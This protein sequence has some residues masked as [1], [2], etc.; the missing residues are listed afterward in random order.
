[1]IR[2]STS[3]HGDEIPVRDWSHHAHNFLVPDWTLLCPGDQILV[4]ELPGQWQAGTVDQVAEAGDVL[5]MRDSALNSRRL[6]HTTDVAGIFCRM[7][8]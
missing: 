8:L 3:L 6:I 2:G 4:Q 1:M 7:R 5:W